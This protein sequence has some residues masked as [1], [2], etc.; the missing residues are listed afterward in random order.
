MNEDIEEIF[1]GKLT[2]D[3]IDI[4]ISFMEY[5]GNSTD[6]IVYYNDGDIPVYS[7]EDEPIYSNN[8]L[9]FNIYTKGNY[10][11]IIKELK[12]IMKENDYDWTG[13][14]EDLYESDTKYHHKV[15]SFQKIRRI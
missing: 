14:S 10:L 12:K 4:P 11:K 6:Y 13:D 3:K 5:T 1:N 9:E 2:I 15:V 8:E 7:A